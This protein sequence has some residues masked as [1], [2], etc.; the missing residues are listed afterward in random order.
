MPTP[1][2]ENQVRE[3]WAAENGHGWVAE[4]A[5]EI[6]GYAFFRT[7]LPESEL[8]HL[9]VTPAKRRRGIARV[10]LQRALADL[11]VKGCS[12]CL[13][14]VRESNGAA[15]KLYAAMGFTPVGRRK[16]Y[17]RHPIEDA[18]LLHRELM[19]TKQGGA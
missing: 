17:Y 5:G 15:R 14:E 1:W 8:L 6:A 18:L 4:E 13:L 2:S 3:E 12:C 9:V 16:K 10:L 19:E 11:A 7:C